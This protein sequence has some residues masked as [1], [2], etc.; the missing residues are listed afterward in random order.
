MLTLLAKLLKALNGEGSP[1]QVSAG[2][3]FGMM[4]G[5]VPLWSFSNLFI[6]FLV[7]ILRVN[8]TGFL[9]FFGVFSGFAYLVDPM[10]EQ[11]GASLL[12]SLALVG[13][14]S[15]LYGS[16]LMRLTH[17]NNTLVLGAMVIS[18]VLAVPFYFGSNFLVSKYRDHVLSWV[19]KSKLMTLL[20]ASKFYRIYQ[21]LYG[22][23]A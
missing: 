8:V 3:T 22:G 7:C 15:Q 1:A 11:L 20:K 9:L 19:R 23:A 2:F 17:F 5:L 4:V 14:W 21:G 16:E 12:Q 13:F 6:L 10:M 18:Y